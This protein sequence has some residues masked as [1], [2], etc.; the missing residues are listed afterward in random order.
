[1]QIAKKC[2]KLLPEALRLQIAIK[3][4]RNIGTVSYPLTLPMSF[5]KTLSRCNFWNQ[6][7]LMVSSGSNFVKYV[8]YQKQTLDDRG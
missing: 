7:I 3:I 5:A 6:H 2:L 1:M 4:K 8:P